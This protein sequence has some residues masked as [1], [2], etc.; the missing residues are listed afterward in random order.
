VTMHVECRDVPSSIRDAGGDETHRQATAEWVESLWREK[1][2][3][4]T[5]SR[6]QAD[7]SPEAVP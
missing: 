1:D 5:D 7:F 2:A 3:R 4:L 6:M